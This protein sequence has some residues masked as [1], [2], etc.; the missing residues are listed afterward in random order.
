MRDAKS[1][2]S[3]SGLESCFWTKKRAHTHQPRQ[4]M[5]IQLSLIQKEILIDGLSTLTKSSI[6]P[7]TLIPQ[8]WRTFLSGKL[9]THLMSNQPWQR[10]KKAKNN[11]QVLMEFALMYTSM[12][13]KQLESSFLTCTSYAGKRQPYLRTSKRQTL[14][15]FIVW[16]LMD[17]N[18]VVCAI[19]GR[20]ILITFL[21][22]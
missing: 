21:V 4:K 8:S 12:T 16:V 20:S 17:K 2:K 14:Y 11:L 9:T 6:S 3:L 1:G 5:G 18:R 19:S 22:R 10:L 15:T 7:P 13:V